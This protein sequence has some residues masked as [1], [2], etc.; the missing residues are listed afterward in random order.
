MS[1]HGLFNAFWAGFEP[2][3]NSPPTLDQT[4]AYVDVVTLAFTG[5][6]DDNTYNT[7]FLCS[8]YP[9]ATIEFHA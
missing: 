7:D 3:E 5:P 9:A 1:D 4:P 2:L 8:K 6:G